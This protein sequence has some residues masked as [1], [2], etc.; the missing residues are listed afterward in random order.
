MLK[1]LLTAARSQQGSGPNARE[2]P[3]LCIMQMVCH[4]SPVFWASKATQASILSVSSC[5]VH[6]VLSR[7]G[8]ERAHIRPATYR[9]FPL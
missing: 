8:V 7:S 4:I 1:F 6:A 9:L 3:P 2:P 5:A